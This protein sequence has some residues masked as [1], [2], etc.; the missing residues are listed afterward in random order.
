MGR[1][2]TAFTFNDPLDICRT[3]K[4]SGNQVRGWM[5]GFRVDSVGPGFLAQGPINHRPYTIPIHMY[6]GPP[7]PDLPL[8]HHWLAQH[9]RVQHHRHDHLRQG[10]QAP[11][12]LWQRLPVRCGLIDLFA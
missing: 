4:A 1:G 8:Q 11:G 7:A 5:L 3:Y 6:T 12:S 9:G 2:C 10:L